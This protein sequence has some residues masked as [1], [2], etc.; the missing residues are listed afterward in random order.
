MPGPR[1]WLLA[2]W[3][4]FPQWAV[5]YLRWQ[6]Q[7]ASSGST[8]SQGEQG[9]ELLGYRGCWLTGALPQPGP[10]A[11]AIS[12]KNCSRFFKSL[13]GVFGKFSRVS[14]LG[15]A[16]VWEEVRGFQNV[17][18]CVSCS[19]FAPMWPSPGIVWGM[20]KYPV[21]KTS[22]ER[23]DFPQPSPKPVISWIG[24][25]V[26]SCMPGL[27]PGGCSCQVMCLACCLSKTGENPRTFPTL[28][29]KHSTWGGWAHSDLLLLQVGLWVSTGPQ[30]MLW[31]VLWAHKNGE[32]P[33]PG[34]EFP[35]VGLANT[36]KTSG[37]DS[38]PTG[39]PIKQCLD[40][41]VFWQHGCVSG[42]GS[43]LQI[44]LWTLSANTEAL[45]RLL[46]FLPGVST[47]QVGMTCAHPRHTL[48]HQPHRWG[49]SLSP[50]MAP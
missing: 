23:G 9:E 33:K 31:C 45:Q 44:L 50:A 38:H 35:L 22:G 28:A 6:E 1:R 40:T 37:S 15:F 17:Q 43:C 46:G 18:S 13:W 8:K 34:T 24:C 3:G 12:W 20:G 42:G 11:R 41:A 36:E 19:L 27:S 5:W 26:P 10:A 21:I 25:V 47:W 14:N 32:W 48:C 39:C 4:V 2:L 29:D 30:T 16:A 7:S 49:V